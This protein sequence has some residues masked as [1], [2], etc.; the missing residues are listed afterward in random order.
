MWLTAATGDED[1]REDSAECFLLNPELKNQPKKTKQ[2]KQEQSV[3][4]KHCKKSGHSIDECFVLHPELKK[5]KQQNKEQSVTCKHCKK[6]GHSID[7]C[8]V[9]HP[10]LKN[11][12]KKKGKKTGEE[13]EEEPDLICDYCKMPGHEVKLCFVLNPALMPSQP[14]GGENKELRDP[15]PRLRNKIQKQEMMGRGAMPEGIHKLT[16]VRRI[17]GWSPA[18]KAYY[19]LP[20]YAV[21]VNKPTTFANMPIVSYEAY[22][23]S[24]DT[25]M[26]YCDYPKDGHHC[27]LQ[28]WVKRAVDKGKD[29]KFDQDSEE[30]FGRI[31]AQSHIDRSD[32]TIIS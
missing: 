21:A 14:G 16:R 2:Q 22:D 23:P 27:H 24:G 1:W 29:I 7:E 6:S 5:T 11:Q 4:C 12:P 19:T 8:F 25:V 18:R 15:P 32:I 10:E 9:L 13:E 31:M 30:A 3:T 20:L 26:C 28:H 17:Q